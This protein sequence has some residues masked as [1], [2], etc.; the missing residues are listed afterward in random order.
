MRPAKHRLISGGL[1]LLILIVV[2]SFTLLVSSDMRWFYV[3]GSVLLFFGAIWTQRTK[4]DW[5]AASLLYLPLLI[6]FGLTVLRQLPALWPQM[7]LWPAAATTGACLNKA[8][9]LRA[10]AISVACLLLLVSL[11]YC[12]SYIPKRIADSL[13]R[14]QDAAA[15]TFQLEPV[16][17]GEVPTGPTPGKILVLDFFAT[18]CGPCIAELPELEHVRADLQDKTDI[19]FVVVASAAGRDT[20]E[21]LKK[22]AQQRN[23]ALPLAFDPTGKVEASFGFTG[24]PV[25]IVL[26][27]TGRVRFTHQGYNDSETYFRRDLEQFLKTL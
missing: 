15:P 26:D 13:G 9:K 16:S 8:P 24:F 22:F 2:F 4:R 19:Q 18:W 23:I 27:R 3:T 5:L 17:D 1:G 14:F 12:L 25:L 10:L 7:L 21:K 20:S 11:W 6:G